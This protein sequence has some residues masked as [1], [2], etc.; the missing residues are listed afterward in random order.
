MSR[1]HRNPPMDASAI[2]RV[3]VR[4]PQ[5]QSLAS[6]GL[7]QALIGLYPTGPLFFWIGDGKYMGKQN[8]QS[9][10]MVAWKGFS[11]PF[12]H[13]KLIAAVK[14]SNE[15]ELLKILRSSNY[16]DDAIRGA[17]VYPKDEQ[18][19]LY[20]VRHAGLPTSPVTLVAGSPF[21]LD[22]IGNTAS[23]QA[24]KRAAQPAPYP[25]IPEGSGV[26]AAQ[27]G[28]AP[29]YGTSSTYYGQPQ[30]FP[31]TGQ[32]GYQIPY[33]A[34]APSMPSSGYVAGKRMPVDEVF[35]QVMM[36][37]WVRAHEAGV[38]G[39]K[40]YVN[41]QGAPRKNVLVSEYVG[42]NIPNVP[43]HRPPIADVPTEIYH[44]SD[45]NNRNSINPIPNE[46]LPQEVFKLWMAL[47]KEA[48]GDEYAAVRRELTKKK[49]LPMLQNPGMLAWRVLAP[50]VRG[51]VRHYVCQWKFLGEPHTHEI[52][53]TV[54]YQ[55]Q[56]F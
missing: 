44:R 37:L 11:E 12:E 36:D 46:V 5:G 20:Q 25:M 32:T 30:A 45:L 6:R 15:A 31:Y 55:T 27:V 13:A 19:L 51:D 3:F 48:K 22:K 4:V 56:G 14:N 7:K 47:D 24:A 10:V 42:V 38:E 53:G 34:Y 21:F 16:P 39:P 23:E 17:H 41:W 35:Q 52:D 29:Y 26:T 2:G 50:V 9:L 18:Y 40:E 8:E 54:L 28:S 1:A 33:P 49:L 43:G